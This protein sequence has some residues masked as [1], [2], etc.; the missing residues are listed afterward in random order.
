M[1]S[2]E[3]ASPQATPAD[4]PTERFSRHRWWDSGQGW[5]NKLNNLRLILQPYVFHCLLLPWL[6]LFDIPGLRT[7]FRE[8]IAIMNL[9]HA[10]LLI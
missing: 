7:G 6:L 9:F 1:P 3:A 10:S 2:E 4:A 5:K 8:L